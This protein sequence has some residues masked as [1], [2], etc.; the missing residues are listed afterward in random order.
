VY[1]AD[2]LLSVDDSRLD[3][4][5]ERN[6]DVAR[7]I[8][9]TSPY[10]GL[11][12][13]VI[14]G[15]MQRVAQSVLTPHQLQIWQHYVDGKSVVEIARAMSKRSHVS[16]V[17]SLRGREKQQEVGI[18]KK[19]QRALEADEDFMAAAEK[20]VENVDVEGSPSAHAPSAWFKPSI[21]R[22]EAFG[23]L[24]VLLC[25]HAA[26]DVRRQVR[27]DSLLELAPRAALEAGLK[28]LR[29]AGYVAYDGIT[30]TVVR[31]PI[32]PEQTDGR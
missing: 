11:V 3:Y 6:G 17:Y 13:D 12:C 7:H 10:A 15:H 22:P 20:A 18:V 28:W 32:D 2:K 29:G 14:R 4:L 31:T 5:V 16:V 30:V 19:M 23:P 25:C 27:F 1:A 24:A 9:A 21:R 26:A 8:P